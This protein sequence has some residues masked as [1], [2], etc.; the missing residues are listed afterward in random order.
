MRCVALIEALSVL[1]SMLQ[2]QQSSI[3]CF[4]YMYIIRICMYIVHVHVRMWRTLEAGITCMYIPMETG[5]INIL[6][7]ERNFCVTAWAV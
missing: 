6:S 5:A 4:M 3:K 7:N 2:Q 1:I